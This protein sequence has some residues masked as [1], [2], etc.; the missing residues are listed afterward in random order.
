MG[1]PGQRR[2]LSGSA[3]MD[4]ETGGICMGGGASTVSIRCWESTLLQSSHTL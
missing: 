4:R 1:I 2:E 3:L